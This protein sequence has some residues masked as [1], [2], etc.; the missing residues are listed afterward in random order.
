MVG[1]KVR[2]ARYLLSPALAQRHLENNLGSPF[3]GYIALYAGA[4]T[5]HMAYVLQNFR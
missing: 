3:F 4:R 2:R 5:L 1:S